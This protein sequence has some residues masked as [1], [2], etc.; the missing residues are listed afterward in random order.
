MEE[1]SEY[2]NISRRPAY[3]LFAKQVMQSA[4]QFEFYM[5]VLLEQ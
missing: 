4:Q 2:F 5:P 3:I 1:N